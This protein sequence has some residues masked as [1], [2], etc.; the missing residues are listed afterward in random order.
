MNQETKNTDNQT[1]IV[2]VM[3]HVDHGKTSLLD[4]IRGTKVTAT[5]IG[6]ITQSVR[7]H[8][9]NYK[10]RKI[11]FIDT[12]GHEAFANMRSRGS[13]IANIA[14]IVIAKDDGIQPQTIQAATFAKAQN[15]PIIIALNKIDKPGENEDKI[16]AQLASKAGVSPEYL[17][18]DA[19]LCK[20][21]ALTG[22]G[23]NELLDNILLINEIHG[24][25]SPI[26]KNKD[27]VAEGLVLESNVTKAHGNVALIILKRGFI[28]SKKETFAANQE[29]SSKIRNL[30]NADQKIVDSLSEGDPIWVTGLDKVL[31]VGQ[32]VRFFNDKKLAEKEV[33]LLQNLE[34]TKQAFTDDPF[35]AFKNLLKKQ[36]KIEDKNEKK[37]LN[38]LL[39]TDTRGSMEVAKAE[40]VRLS[41]EFAEI[42]LTEASEGEISESDI[43]KAK[44]TGAIVVGFRSGVSDNA[45]RVASQERVIVRNYE[46]IYEMIEELEAALGGMLL[47][48]EEEVEVATAIVKIPFKLTNGQWVAGSVVQKGTFLKGYRIKIMRNNEE[49]LK[50][51]ITELRINKNEV[52]EVEKN[53]DCGILIEPN[54]EIQK[55]DKIVAY[56]IEKNL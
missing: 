43:H 6:G 9:I 12:P 56:K 41:D 3:G 5:E 40:I 29:F 36:G 45:E 18:G 55:D 10:D 53:K 52:K 1:P 19:I 30:L 20:V 32:T 7:A 44:D 47:P 38:V 15:L 23:I 48:E 49:V 50:G 35:A 11:T 4:T 42:K 51:K 27:I 25:K 28:D 13:K 24:S 22:E 16:F 26:E 14:I 34:N 31:N 21:S 33:I 39:K 17:G 46:I 54:F 2:A 37:I 8:Q